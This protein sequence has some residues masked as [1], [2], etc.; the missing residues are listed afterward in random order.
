MEGGVD[1]TLDLAPRT[2]LTVCIFVPDIAG[3]SNKRFFFF[4][5]SLGHSTE[6]A[7][8]LSSRRPGLKWLLFPVVYAASGYRS[9]RLGTQALC[10]VS[11]C[12]F[13]W[14]VGKPNT[15]KPLASNF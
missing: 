10:W 8:S 7:Y 1:N 6:H 2:S 9:D 15:A 13:I 11:C 4:D 14:E 3:V 5:G 12:L